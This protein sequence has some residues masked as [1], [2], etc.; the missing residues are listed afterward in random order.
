[1][2]NMEMFDNP[3]YYDKFTVAQRDLQSISLN[4]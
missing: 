2:K 4:I 1:M 3:D